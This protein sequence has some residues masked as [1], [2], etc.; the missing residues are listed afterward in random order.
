MLEYCI[1]DAKLN[2]RVYEALKKESKG[3]SRQSVE[4]EH[5]SVVLEAKVGAVV[6]PVFGK[7][8]VLEAEPVPMMQST[9]P[10]LLRSMQN[11]AGYE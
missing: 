8:P 9:R 1:R 3:F 7:N 10:S 11:G 4:L 5:V 6:E 2:R